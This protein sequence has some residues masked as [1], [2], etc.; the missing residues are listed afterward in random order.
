MAPLTGEGFNQVI[1]KV[2]RTSAGLRNS[3]IS[4]PESS[5][6]SVVATGPSWVRITLKR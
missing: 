2:K 3:L 6:L 5:S 1:K 4:E